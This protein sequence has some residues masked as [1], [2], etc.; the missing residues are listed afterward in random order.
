MRLALHRT[1]DRRRQTRC[2][3]RRRKPERRQLRE[4]GR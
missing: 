4:S 1:R 3:Q 2:S